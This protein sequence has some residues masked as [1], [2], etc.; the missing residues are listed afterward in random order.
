MGG[1]QG[2]RGVKGGR[3]GVKKKKEAGSEARG[4][5]I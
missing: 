4:E 3:Q 1:R 5:R 2:V